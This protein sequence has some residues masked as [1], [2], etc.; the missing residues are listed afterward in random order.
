MVSCGGV[1]RLASD[2]GRLDVEVAICEQEDHVRQV[3]R[4]VVIEG[5][6]G[7]HQALTENFVNLSLRRTMPV[8]RVC[9]R[10]D[11]GFLPAVAVVPPAPCTTST[12]RVLGTS[13]SLRLASVRKIPSPRRN[14]CSLSPTRQQRASGSISGTDPLA[15]ERSN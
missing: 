10:H 5:A 12:A 8:N 1:A 15:G 7:R 11:A 14:L 2:G 9:V 4:S 3:D 13:V 6:E